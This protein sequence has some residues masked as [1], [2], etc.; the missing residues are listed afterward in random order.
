MLGCILFVTYIN[1]LGQLTNCGLINMFSD[2]VAFY[3]TGKTV[4]E[5]NGKLQGQTNDIA[6]WHEANRLCVNI[7]KSNTILVHSRRNGNIKYLH[8]SLKGKKNC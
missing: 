6:D 8:I 4:R 2:D 5:V 1:D 7:N 3:T